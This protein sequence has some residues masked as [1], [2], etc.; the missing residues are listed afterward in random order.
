MK[1]L[2]NNL[3]L[4]V[5]AGPILAI[6]QLTKLYIDSSMSLYSSIT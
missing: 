2:Y 6:D 1:N 4:V 5:V 3:T